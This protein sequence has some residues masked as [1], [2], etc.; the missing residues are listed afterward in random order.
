MEAHEI[1]L[2]GYRHVYHVAAPERPLYPPVLAVHGFGSSGLQSFRYLVGPFR[3]YGI[4]LYALDLLGS[5][6][7]QKPDLV[8]SLHLFA[9]LITEWVERLGVDNPVL[10]GHSMGGK[11]AAATAAAHPEY[12][13]ALVL[14][15][16][17]GFQR[18][19]A[20]LPVVLQ[21]PA[22]SRLVEKRWFTKHVL[23]GTPLGK[24]MA[25]EESRAHLIR[26]KRSFHH[27]DLD[28][29]GFRE[30]LHRISLPVLALHGDRDRIIR[31]DALI[32]IRKDLPQSRTVVIRNAGHLLMKD[33]P[34]LFTRS[35][36]SFLDQHT[37]G[38]QANRFMTVATDEA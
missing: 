18:N 19:E 22:I 31:R 13:G 25:R 4:P 1:E 30:R 8:Y 2:G 27:L 16:S 33:Q 6:Q 34:I 11:I 20:L 35:L 12:Y 29:T 26:L 38:H 5:G 24:V 9:D 7:S 36:K 14:A 37:T 3:Q 28:R 15:A 23:Y 32:R 17:A 10:L 21:H